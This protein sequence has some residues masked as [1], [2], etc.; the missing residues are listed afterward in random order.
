MLASSDAITSVLPTLWLCSEAFQSLLMAES[1][2]RQRATTEMA[3]MVFLRDCLYH[4][5]ARL[6]HFTATIFDWILCSDDVVFTC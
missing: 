3:T 4:D 2:K 5:A 6:H 1:V